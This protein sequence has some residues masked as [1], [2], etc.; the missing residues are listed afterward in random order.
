MFKLHTL[1]DHSNENK[2]K[3]SGYWPA[4]AFDF[5]NQ[6]LYSKAVEVCREHLDKEPDLIS[7]RLIYAR[8]L[9]YAGQIDSSRIQF[10]KVI[11]KDPENITALKYLG[12]LNYSEKN[13][14]G[15]MA[16]YEKVLTLNPVSSALKSKIDSNRFQTTRTIT[17]VRSEEIESQKK[18]TTLREIPFYTETIGD[19]YLNQ[20]F[21]RLAAEVFK[22][23]ES[24]QSNPRI[25]DKLKTAEVKIKEK[26]Q[27]YVKKT[28]R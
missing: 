9:F 19:L 27:K 10:N 12:D 6:S 1:V 8:A 25:Y 18:E 14:A 11:S 4:I 2:L 21:P 22:R 17:L 23:L 16:C 7:G 13:I 26:E 3:E 15:A 20:G 5:L 28:N 24:R